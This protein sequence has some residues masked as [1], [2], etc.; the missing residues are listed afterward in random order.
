MARATDAEDCGTVPAS[1]GRQTVRALPSRPFPPARRVCSAGSARKRRKT[2]RANLLG[3][4]CDR[5]RTK[6]VN[7]NANPI[8]SGFASGSAL[9]WDCPMGP[10]GLRA[11]SAARPL[12]ASSAPPACF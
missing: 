1:F 3:P 10:A 11:R 9:L 8:I 2:A 6:R 5:T 7:P 4:L 12:P